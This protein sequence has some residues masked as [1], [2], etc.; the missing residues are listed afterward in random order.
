[1]RAFGLLIMTIT[2]CQPPLSPSRPGAAPVGKADDVGSVD[3]G[4][5]AT[6]PATRTQYRFDEWDPQTGAYVL[7]ENE[8]ELT[9]SCRVKDLRVTC[10][11]GSTWG[12]SWPDGS[13][14]TV[15]IAAEEW[16]GAQGYLRGHMPGDGTIEIDGYDYT[17]PHHYGDYQ[18]G[19]GRSYQ[20]WYTDSF[21]GTVIA[22]L[23]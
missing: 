8:Q 4:F 3:A 18:D 5:T 13:W 16:D 12:A 19:P 1:M 9:F 15:A 11:T 6:L 7:E 2:A 23:Q 17:L 21:S 10:L 20:L 22:P 14:I